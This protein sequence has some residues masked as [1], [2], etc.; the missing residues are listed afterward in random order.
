MKTK[1][2]PGKPR[3]TIDD[4]LPKSGEIAHTGEGLAATEVRGLAPE[5]Y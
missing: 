1:S 2:K 4:G 5:E 3:A